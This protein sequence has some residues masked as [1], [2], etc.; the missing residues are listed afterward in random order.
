M[1]LNIKTVQYYY[2]N[3]KNKKLIENFKDIKILL[4]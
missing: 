2:I 1:N 3:L 4:K